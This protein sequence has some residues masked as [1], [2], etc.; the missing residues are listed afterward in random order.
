[1][2]MILVPEYTHV[3]WDFLE[4]VDLWG[5]KIGH[6]SRKTNAFLSPQWLEKQPTYNVGPPAMFVDL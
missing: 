4:M 6:I 5:S 2:A 1:M 3:Y